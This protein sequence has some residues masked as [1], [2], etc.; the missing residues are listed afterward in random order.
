M[1]RIIA[2]LLLSVLASGASAA[3]RYEVKDR[4]GFGSTGRLVEMAS[5]FGWDSYSADF[6]FGLEPGQRTITKDSVLKLTIHRRDGSDWSTKCKAK[7][8]D[9]M[10]ANVNRL[11][12]K[13]VS[14]LAECRV[15]PGEFAKL[16]KLDEGLVGDPTLVFQAMVKD[17]EAEAGIQKGFYFLNAA[18]IEAGELASFSTREGDPSALSVVFNSAMAPY[19]NHPAYAMR[20]RFLP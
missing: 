5:R 15:A 11:Y 7:H 14:V 18:E 19:V 13:G 9:R 17:G 3:E 2:A 1:K 6:E 20:P 16:V 10:W 8:S 4:G 12:N